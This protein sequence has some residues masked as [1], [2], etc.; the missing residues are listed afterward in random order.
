[1]VT[2]DWKN[3]RDFKYKK[4]SFPK[5]IYNL[6]RKPIYNLDTAFKNILD[7]SKIYLTNIVITNIKPTLFLIQRLCA[8]GL[9][10]KLNGISV[11]ALNAFKV[12]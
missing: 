1:M 3:I 9:M 2:A 4:I 11:I 6:L 5:P 7:L 12:N 8:V 10:A